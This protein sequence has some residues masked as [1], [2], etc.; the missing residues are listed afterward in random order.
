ME[1]GLPSAEELPA[2][3]VSL[4]VPHEDIDQLVALLPG[5]QRTPQA[6]SLLSDCAAALVR[7]MG[8]LDPPPALPDL[9]VTLGPLRRYFFAYV[10]LAALPRVAQ[11]HAARGIPDQI[12]RLTLA[13]LGRRFA[14]HRKRYGE[15]GLSEPSW[16]TRHF[17]GTIYQ[18]GRLQFERVRLGTRFG[19]AVTA[20][21]LPY[22]PGDAALSV[23]IPD[24][25]G[26]LSP[27]AC[28][29]S[30]AR[31]REFFAGHFPEEDHRV[32]ICISWLLDEQLAEYLPADSNIVRF[33]RRFRPA[34]R[35]DPDDDGIQ[36][37]V[38]GATGRDPGELPRRT[39][40]ER[41]VADHLSAGR[42]WHGGAGWLTL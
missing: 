12:S 42:R 39:T 2:I 3:L 10:Y 5:P 17:R 34:Y 18:L 27:D 21:G 13:D 6:W 29:D 40:L 31:A 23:H 8:S 38:F 35:P 41:A 14:V 9:P 28:D 22:G 30:F 7:D 15:S 33:Q 25:Y 1:Y 36:R 11:F 37:F 19:N 24:F 16:L 4:A 20:A 32:A 26:P